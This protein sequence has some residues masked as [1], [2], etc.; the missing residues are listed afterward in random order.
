MKPVIAI[1][2]SESISTEGQLQKKDGFLRSPPITAKKKKKK[3]ISYLLE[4][5][6]FSLRRFIPREDIPDL[7]H[8]KL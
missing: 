3:E 8:T 6:R 7:N 5:I 1:A 4:Q 2:A